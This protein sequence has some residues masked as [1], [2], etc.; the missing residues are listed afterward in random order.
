MPVIARRTSNL[1]SADAKKR[2]AALKHYP[3]IDTWRNPLTRVIARRLSNDAWRKTLDEIDFEYRL[4]PTN[5]AGVPCVEYDAA[6]SADEGSLILYVHGGGFVAGSPEI[7]AANVLP[8]CHLAG[9]KGVGVDYTLL[10]EAHFPVQI[11]EVDKV[12]R[13]L[14]SA[15]PERKIIVLAESTGAAIALAAIMRWRRDGVLAPAGVI[16]LS[17]CVDGEGASDTQITADG[18]DPLI[19]SMGGKYTKSLFRFY[20]PGTPLSEPEV[21]PIYGDFDSMPPMMIHVGSREVLL[22]DAARLSEAA[23]RAGVDVRLRVL[24]GMFHRFH[25]HWNLEEAREAHKDLAD[26]IR[27]L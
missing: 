8:I 19:R 6:G 4:S 18:H 16:L 15:E 11:E 14:V 17:P 23:R 9:C 26:F 21:S 2:I 13:A 27:G 1:I 10:P 12:Y 7:S 22:G 20:A 25:M 24:D 3:T 5:I